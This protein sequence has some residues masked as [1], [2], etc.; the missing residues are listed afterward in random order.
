MAARSREKYLSAA[1]AVTARIG[2][3]EL[4]SPLMN[5]SGVAAWPWAMV[6]S[7]GRLGHVGVTIRSSR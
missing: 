6:P 2:A 4:R 5:R 3:G 1:V 7:W